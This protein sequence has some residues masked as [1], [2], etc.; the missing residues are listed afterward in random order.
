M[1]VIPG[2]EPYRHDGGD[3]GVLLCH[4]FTGC[5]QSLRPWA[6][7]LADHGLSV[8]LPLLPG[9]G[10]DWRD[11]AA[12]AWPAWYGEVDAALDRL[13]R[14]CGTVVVAGLSMGGAL[15]L[16]LALERPAD[17][18]GLVL[19]N[20]AVR[21]RRHEELLPPLLHRVL[22]SVRSIGGDL[23]RTDVRELAYDRTPLGALV[24]MLRMYRDIV[25]RLDGVTQP[26]LLLRSEVD[27]VV[28][29]A[30]SSLVLSRISSRDVTEVV[31]HDSWHVATLDHD[32]GTITAESLAF[33]GRISGDGGR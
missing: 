26:V 12:T 18:A 14:R 11:L 16:R 32:A 17:V 31:L 29:A 13:R 9:H 25:A 22:P 7:D 24:S 20:P 8:E 4:G 5:P 28:P 6:H 30:S 10:T 21:L 27:H 23:R 19:V 1:T 3:V 33:V 2:A 15:A